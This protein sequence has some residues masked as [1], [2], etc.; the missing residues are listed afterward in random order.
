MRSTSPLRRRN[1]ASRLELR[2][3]SSTSRLS[4][5]ELPFRES[6]QTRK[7]G[8]TKWISRPGRALPKRMRTQIRIRKQHVMRQPTTRRAFRTG[9][10][11]RRGGTSTASSPADRVGD[12]DRASCCE[13]SIVRCIDCTASRR[14]IL[15]RTFLIALRFAVG[16]QCPKFDSQTAM[17]Y[18]VNY[19]LV[20]LGSRHGSLFANCRT[21]TMTFPTLL[22]PTL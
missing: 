1:G 6:P 11:L 13:S 2:N 20:T 18:R 19:S 9:A 5:S 15:I 7:R 12:C 14:I 16:S 4:T 3:P 10:G 21:A 22:T 17:R 8:P